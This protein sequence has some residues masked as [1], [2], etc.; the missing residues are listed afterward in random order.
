MH[1]HAGVATDGVDGHLGLDVGG[2]R[3]REVIAVGSVIS[4]D[5]GHGEGS[6]A[7]M[8]AEGGG[9]GGGD[10]VQR[11]EG[12]GWRTMG[13]R[14]RTRLRGRRGLGHAFDKLGAFWFWFT[15]CE[16]KRERG[17]EGQA[18][19]AACAAVEDMAK[20]SIFAC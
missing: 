11:E 5:R 9:R 17:R 7:V 14:F 2:L 18:R 10:G 8:C 4:L 20:T 16:P 15:W 3:I 19:A 13:V 6:G 12:R 1:G